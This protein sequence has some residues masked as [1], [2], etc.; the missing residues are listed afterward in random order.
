MSVTASPQRA[1]DRAFLVIL[2]AGISAALHVGKLPPALPVLQQE[3]GLSLVQAG[4]LLSLVQLGSMLLGL[5]AG[6]LA[7]GLGLRRCMIAGLVL[8]ALAGAAGGFAHSATALLVLRGLEG[9]GFL[10]VTVPAPSLVRRT[11]RASQLTRRL[12]VWGSFMPV[13]TAGAL[14]L[15]PLVIALMGWPVWWWLAAGFSALMALWVAR[16]VP[17]DAVGSATATGTPAAE[18]WTQRLLATLRSG[19]PWLAALAF[20]VYSAQWLAVI[21]FLP[22]LY[23]QSGWGGALG[24]VLTALVAGI[25]MLGNVGAGRLLQRGV[26]PQRL[27]WCGYAAMAV[28]TFLAFSA[29]TVGSP[30]LRYGGALLFSAVGGLIPGT[31]FAL[32]P[33]LAPGE[34][35]IAT[36]VGWMQQWSA[37]GQMAGPPLVAWVAGQAGGWQLTWLVT[38]ACC[39][40]GALLAALIAR[41]L[42]GR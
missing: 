5:V 39:A 32:A 21:G 17:P 30:A 14:L 25:N 23:Q 2:L 20:A 15:G 8:L 40:A 7:D 31:L 24:A 34:Q 41:R 12:G 38:G 1:Q 19:G 10:L 42:A 18:P 36:T 28:G 29:V 33:R 13:G 16:V 3:L 35:T 11:A 27:L 4:F 22:S 6:L 37:V 9:M 26:A